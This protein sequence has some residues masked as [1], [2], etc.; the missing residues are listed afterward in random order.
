MTKKL[1]P[2]TRIYTTSRVCACGTQFYGIESKVEFAFRLHN[3]V[4]KREHNITDMELS[5]MMIDLNKGVVGSIGKDCQ[6]V[7]D[8]F[9]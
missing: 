4:C 5:D 2:S 9:C 3:R 8:I 7:E 1:I 6:T